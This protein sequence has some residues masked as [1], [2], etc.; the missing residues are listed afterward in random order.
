V[1]F[2]TAPARLRALPSWLLNQAAL[3]AQRLV[4]DGLGAVGAH[5]SHYAVLT[6]LAE[7]GP[8]SQAALGRRCGIDRSDMVALVNDLAGD[9][10][11]DRQPDADD[12]RRNVITITPAGRRHL[13]MLDSVVARV[14]DALL[15]PLSAGERDQLVALLRRVVEHHGR[16]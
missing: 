16:A 3:R 11:V 6:A 5:R 4:A 1:E 12:R 13:R 2:D 7:F 15:E 8:D 10:L 14:Q 9:R